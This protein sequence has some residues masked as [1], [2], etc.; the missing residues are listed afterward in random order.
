MLL[1]S[2]IAYS[3]DTKGNQTAAICLLTTQQQDFRSYSI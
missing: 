3:T 1:L 2:V